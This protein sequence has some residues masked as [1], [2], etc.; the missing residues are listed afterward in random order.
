MEGRRS[1]TAWILALL[2]FFPG[3]KYVSASAGSG[4]DGSFSDPWQLSYAL[5]N[6]SPGDTVNLFAG[7]YTASG[8]GVAV[9][10]LEVSGTASQ[11]IVFRNYQTDVCSLSSYEALNVTDRHYWAIEG[12]R[13]HIETGAAR[14][15]YG[16]SWWILKDCRFYGDSDYPSDGDSPYYSLGIDS[17]FY[18]RIYSTLVDREDGD[19]TPDENYIGD[20]IRITT[21]SQ[22]GTVE[23]CEVTRVGH[24]ALAL[25]ADYQTHPHGRANGDGRVKNMVL[26]DNRLHYI[27][28]GTGGAFW[29]EWNMWEGNRVWYPERC[30]A[31]RGGNA[32]QVSTR[33][34]VFRFNIGWNDTTYASSDWGS[35]HQT[36]SLINMYN[37]VDNNDGRHATFSNRSYQETYYGENDSPVGHGRV[38]QG[39]YQDGFDQDANDRQFDDNKFK[40]VMWVTPEDTVAV[41][42]HSL[43]I[44]KANWDWLFEKCLFYRPGA[45]DIWRGFWSGDADFENY[46]LAELV[47]AMPSAYVDNVVDDPE[48]VD[49]TNQGPSKDFSLSEGSPAID[50][51][52]ALTLTNGSGSSSNIVTVDDASWFF[53]NWGGMPWERG[54]SVLIRSGSTDV[55]AEID[56][57]DYT[58]NRLVLVASTTWADNDSVY[59]WKSWRSRTGQ[60]ITRFRGSRP[61][62][63]AIEYGT[64]EGGIPAYLR[65]RILI[66]REG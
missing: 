48:F 47:S 21:N 28:T 41:V 61:D 33:Y 40:M 59:L 36:A 39:F 10:E 65:R 46:T 38:V 34:S 7:T 12:L 52:I 55:R 30:L 5:Q 56:S 66:H 1:M 32:F 64:D 62:L 2:M 19:N 18:F 35:Y 58:L 63:G 25:D 57:I 26:R 11:W 60:Y 8:S 42:H 29:A 31:S 15:N 4:G 13:F 6:A 37:D 20:G 16:S 22:Y 9:F 54:D 17:C 53:F 43:A 50:A 44:T 49:V 24:V 27:H 51:G 23:D 3:Q 14:I 45:G